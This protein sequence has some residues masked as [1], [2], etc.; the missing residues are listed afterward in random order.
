[1]TGYVWKFP[2][3]EDNGFALLRNPAGKVAVLQASW[4]EWR[5]YR[6][7]IEIYGTQGCIRAS[8]PPM[9]TTMTQI[10]RAEPRPRRRRR[11]FLFPLYRVVERLR[12]YRWTAIKS[13][14]H[15]LEALERTIA[16]EKTPLALGWDGLRAV[17]IAHAV[18]QTSERDQTLQPSDPGPAVEQG[19]AQETTTAGSD[20]GC[21]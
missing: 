7:S 16:G 9:L 15:E 10:I 18:Y 19:D 4:S 21:L 17:E 1:M 8:Y 14:Q 6:F 3:C 5:G 12:S 11:T 20:R 13:F 2:G